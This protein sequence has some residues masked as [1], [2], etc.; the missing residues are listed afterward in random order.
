MA[1]ARL[2]V[3]GLK[4]PETALQVE[5]MLHARPGIEEVRADAETGMLQLRYDPRRV[6][7]PRLRAYLEA[8]GLTS[9]G[10]AG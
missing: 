7:P 8:A 9:L 4:D 3:R 10:D 1:E 6:P 5:A 2:R